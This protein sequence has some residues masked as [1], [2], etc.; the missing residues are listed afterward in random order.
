MTQAQAQAIIKNAYG[1][2]AYA[3]GQSH[4][5]ESK[6]VAIFWLYDGENEEAYKVYIHKEAKNESDR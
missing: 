3:V 1:N 2:N 6:D 4:A 5:V